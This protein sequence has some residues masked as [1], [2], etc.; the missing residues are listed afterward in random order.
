VLHS[1]APNERM[2]RAI[3]IMAGTG[4]FIAAFS[5]TIM[6]A[7]IGAGGSGPR[8]PS[9]WAS[10]LSVPSPGSCC[11]GPGTDPAAKPAESVR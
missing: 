1:I 11:T 4:N 3:G 8:S 6:G 10:S 2:G 5:A 7:L 9:S